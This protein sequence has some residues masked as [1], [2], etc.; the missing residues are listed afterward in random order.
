[1]PK[2][3]VYLV[4]VVL[5]YLASAL[6]CL[7]AHWAWVEQEVAPIPWANDYDLATFMVFDQSDDKLTL[8]TFDF[9]TTIVQVWKFTAP[10]WIMVWEGIPDIGDISPWY[11]FSYLA[12]IY[13]DENLNSIVL[14]G[15]CMGYQFE[16]G[17]HALFKYIPGQGFTRITSH[18]AIDSIYVASYPHFSI[19]FDVK[20]R[21][22]VF[23]GGFTKWMDGQYQFITVEYDGSTLYYIPNNPD[24]PEAVAAFADG[25]CGYDPSIER[26]VFYGRQDTSW[27]LETWEYDGQRWKLIATNEGPRLNYPPIGMIY[28]ADHSGL[29]ALPNDWGAIESWVYRLRKWHKSTVNGQFEGRVHGLLAYDKNR[30]VAVFYGGLDEF[31]KFSN[32]MWELRCTKHCKPVSKPRIPEEGCDE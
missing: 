11:Y 1:M 31:V 20:R 32:R 17:Y 4:V 8:I 16:M 6:P 7:A 25:S 21:R 9:Q 2:M 30:R 14:W 22:A 13:F 15:F 29:L 27:P 3:K 12:N 19:T 26:V 24:P 23:V 18:I 28:V 10:E 5:A